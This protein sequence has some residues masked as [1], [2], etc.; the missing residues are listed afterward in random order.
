MDSCPLNRAPP[1]ACNPSVQGPLKLWTWL[2]RFI[3]TF[4]SQKNTVYCLFI[5]PTIFQDIRAHKRQ[6]GKWLGQ[7]LRAVFHIS[8]SPCDEW[9]LGNGVRLRSG[10]VNHALHERPIHSL[11]LSL[12]NLI[13]LWEAERVTSNPVYIETPK[14]TDNREQC[15]DP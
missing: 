4:P 14:R 12:D 9:V 1:D 15:G 10:L 5:K 11:S 3:E 6:C 8:A 13:F 7:E 2:G